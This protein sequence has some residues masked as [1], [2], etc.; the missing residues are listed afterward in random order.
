MDW[1]R[2]APRRAAKFA[3]LGPAGQWLVLRALGLL[4]RVRLALW[5]L[6]FRRVRDMA[7]RLGRRS[8]SNA[9]AKRFSAED[10]TSFVFVAASYIP[11]AS[12][13][14]QAL[15]ADVLLR[16]YGYEPLL[17]IGVSRPPGKAFQ[18][19]AWVE[20][21]GKVVIG[22]VESLGQYTPL[23]TLGPAATANK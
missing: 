6:P 15:V 19:H 9:T 21:D 1:L 3:R 11:R 12:C 14:T 2:S 4:L 23:P 8:R 5:L 18:A 22:H 7:D 10:L 20:L 17:K 16:R 13:L